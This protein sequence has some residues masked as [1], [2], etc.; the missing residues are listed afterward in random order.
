MSKILLHTCCGPCS[1]YVVKSLR[2]QGFDVTGYFY[3]PNIN[4]VEEYQR[5]LET[6][7]QYAKA[8]DLEVF[9]PSVPTA[10]GHLPLGK[11]ENEVRLK[12]K[13]CPNCYR[14][15]LRKTAESAK[16]L[17]FEAFSTTLLISPYQKIE[18]IKKIGDEI[19]AQVG[20]KFLCQDFQKGYRES[21]QLARELNL[22]MQRYCGC[23]N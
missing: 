16:A 6:M 20:V 15:R 10:S 17:G 8:V 3:N 2:E 13:D 21:R 18:L 4:P 19:G 7:Q 9:T 11:G 1:T 12:P 22:Y 23:Q 14:V 5:R